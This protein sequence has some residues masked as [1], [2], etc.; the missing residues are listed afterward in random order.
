MLPLLVLPARADV[1]VM[2]G[3]IP[4]ARGRPHADR[5]SGSS[6]TLRLA[7]GLP[8]PNPEALNSLLSQ[9][10]D[11][12]SPLYH[13]YLTPQEFTERFGP[14][15]QDYQTLMGWAK[16]NNLTV[17]ARHP[18]R[19]VLDVSGSVADI[20]NALHV[21]MKVYQH[22]K[23]A[24]TFY[25]PSTEPQVDASI[26][27]LHISGLDNYSLAPSPSCAKPRTTPRP[28]SCPPRDQGRGAITWAMISETPTCRARP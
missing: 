4:Q 24:R 22:P 6:Q 5:R 1:Q 9:I 14:S 17:T 20:Q 11:P 12:S 25:A 13:Q 10:Y 2:Q 8:L 15:E 19:I 28:T 27:I 23:E 18:N 7:I 16:A 21:T 26:P 3:T